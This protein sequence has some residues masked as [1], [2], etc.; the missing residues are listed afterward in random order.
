[1]LRFVSDLPGRVRGDAVRLGVVFNNL[2]TN[3]L[4][5][6]PPGGAVTVQLSSR[7]D[8]RRML[9]VV[10][11]DEG[12]GIPEVYRERVFEKFF[13]VEH[14]G[15][16]GDGGVRGTGIGLYLCR[17][18]IKRHGGEIHCEAGEAGVGT[19]VVFLLPA[20]AAS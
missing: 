12:P 16:E 15:E 6:S 14:Q 3:A 20:A 5:Y 17:E 9:Q 4:K 19:R 11:M 18:I 2:L 1:M 7:S 8:G 13:R 10:V